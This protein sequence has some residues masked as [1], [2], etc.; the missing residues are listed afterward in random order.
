MEIGGIVAFCHQTGNHQFPRVT[1]QIKSK[2]NISK[3]FGKNVSEFGV[4]HAIRTAFHVNR[5][6]SR[7]ALYRLTAVHSW[8]NKNNAENR[9]VFQFDIYRVR[10]EYKTNTV[11]DSYCR[12]WSVKPSSRYKAIQDIHNDKRAGQIHCGREHE[13]VFF[14]S[15]YSRQLNA[16]ARIGSV[17]F[18]QNERAQ[19]T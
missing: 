18:G 4:G 13:K 6:Q 12:G 9:K 1:A 2:M 3:R 14:I 7:S 8:N 5:A 10:N 19:N 16:N 11:P 17:E 15:F